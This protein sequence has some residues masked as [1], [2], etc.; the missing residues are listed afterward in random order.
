LFLLKRYFIDELTER[1]PMKK[2]VARVEEKL[3][4]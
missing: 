1:K 3:R 4:K 2:L